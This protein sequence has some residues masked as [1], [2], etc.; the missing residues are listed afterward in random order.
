VTNSG[1]LLAPEL[2]TDHVAAPAAGPVHP[3][4]VSE[5]T[6]SLLSL[7]LDDIGRY[8]LLSPADEQRLARIVWEAGPPYGEQSSV[9]E[10]RDAYR[11]LIECNLRLVV[12][13]ARRYQGLGLPLLDM[14]QEG[15]IGLHRAV[16]RFDYRKGYRFSTYAYWWIR[17]SVTR[18]I[19]DQGRTI[20]LPI[21]VHDELAQLSRVTAALGQELGRDPRRE[22]IAA[23]LGEPVEKVQLLQEA[24]TFTASLDAPHLAYEDMTLGDLVE[25]PNAEDP[26]ARAEHGSLRDLVDRA[27]DTLT[28]REKAVLVRRFGLN[29][30]DREW[31]LADI[32]RDLGLSRERVR[33]ITDEALAKLRTS[34]FWLKV[35]EYAA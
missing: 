15:N 28:P 19:A 6:E 11:R 24:S 7:Y 13:V 2:E 23:A 1:A 5:S 27:L 14:V 34:Q 21:H 10:A 3:E 20:R 12:S 35:R 33:Q 31:T 25:D 29:G 17:Q 18:A 9:P 4:Q 26:M 32:G 22:E 16:E 8:P 30:G